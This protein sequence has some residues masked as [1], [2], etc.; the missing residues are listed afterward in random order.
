MYHFD[1]LID[2]HGTGSVKWDI[3]K[4]RFRAD[5][6]TA[7]W[8]AD[9][10]F[11]A[12]P[13]VT[14]ALEQRVSHPVYG[15]T[16]QP[17][18][19]A[20]ALCSWYEK[21]HGLQLKPEWV[22]PA[23]HA[24]TALA[25]V[26]RAVTQP[27]DPCLVLT[28][29]YD[30]FFSTVIGADRRLVTM[31][32]TEKQGHYEVNLEELERRF[33][34]GIRC[35]IF[36]NPHNPGGKAWKREELTAIAALCR[37]YDVVILSDD[38]HSDWVFADWGY[39]SFLDIPEA[40]E[41]TVMITSPSKT[42]N[43]AGLCA[44]NLII[45]DETLRG[46]VQR[47][48]AAMF[49]KGPNLLGCVG[50]EAAYLGAGDWVD[51]VRAYVYANG[52]YMKEQLAAYAPELKLFDWEST[53]LL[54]L[55]CRAI[56]PDSTALCKTLAQQYGISVSDGAAYGEGGRGFLRINVATQRKNIETGT[57]ALLRWY[58]DA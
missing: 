8:I 25:I 46:K 42:F 28:P 10:D 50:T 56:Q 21:R 48:M 39:T 26:L 13:C 53:F 24:V 27:G 19:Y 29:A 20:P 38:V 18:Q 11:A 41:R 30:A 7:F 3:Q 9:M 14:Q 16:A 2:R 40:A 4:F 6:L 23:Q 54:W 17:R 22:V 47:E 34:A 58:R 35:L 52:C 5:N 36:C 12:A 32:L 31:P 49:V 33:A 44:S 57:A 43:L 37:A 15:Y 55:D 51:E 1:E 45:A